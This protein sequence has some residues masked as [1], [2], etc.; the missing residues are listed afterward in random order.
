M[1]RIG[2]ALLGFRRQRLQRLDAPNKKQN[3]LLVLRL[4]APDEKVVNSRHRGLRR[5]RIKP[6]QVTNSWRIQ[7]QQYR[8]YEIQLQPLQHLRH[9]VQQQLSQRM[10]QQ[11]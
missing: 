7:G 2:V 6:N 5:I 1:I 11:Q 8:R 10:D 3:Q 9:G 4:D